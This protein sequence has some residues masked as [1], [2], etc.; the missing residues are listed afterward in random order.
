MNTYVHHEQQLDLQA[1]IVM[2]RCMLGL[3]QMVRSQNN[4]PSSVNKTGGLPL[5]EANN[6][7]WHTDLISSMM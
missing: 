3:N 4:L 5:L 6:I 7:K 1:C 2:C